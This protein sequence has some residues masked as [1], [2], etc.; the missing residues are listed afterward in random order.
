[1]ATIGWFRQGDSPLGNFHEI[2][3]DA[4]TLLRLG[5]DLQSHRIHSNQKASLFPTWTH[6]PAALESPRMAKRIAT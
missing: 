3:W 5:F 4:A 2:A 6:D 1:M